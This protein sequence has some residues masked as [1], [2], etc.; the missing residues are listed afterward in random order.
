MPTHDLGEGGLPTAEAECSQ[1]G[2]GQRRPVEAH[3]P[4][5]N[6]RRR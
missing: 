2:V 3:K 4:S 6:E 5:L 1:L